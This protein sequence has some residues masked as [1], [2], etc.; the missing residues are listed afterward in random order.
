[1]FWSV[2]FKSTIVWSIVEIGILSFTRPRLWVVLG[3]VFLWHSMR[4]IRATLHKRIMA[5][6]AQSLPFFPQTLK[7]SGGLYGIYA[8]SD[9]KSGLKPQVIAR[10][11]MMN[12]YPLRRLRK[13]VKSR[14]LCLHCYFRLVMRSISPDVSL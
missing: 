7:V 5:F 14:K 11:S 3:M 6:S 2:Y 13:V 9:D 1:M 12:A 10:L 4:P 8:G